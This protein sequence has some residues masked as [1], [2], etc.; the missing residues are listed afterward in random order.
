MT[1]FLARAAGF[2]LFMFFANYFILY[3]NKA[4]D[5]RMRQ[6]ILGAVIAGVIFGAVL[7]VI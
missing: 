1:Y 2:A 6:S 4:K 3:K 5:T 7:H